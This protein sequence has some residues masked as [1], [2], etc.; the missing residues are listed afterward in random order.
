MM[1][2][3]EDPLCFQEKIFAVPA[4]QAPFLQV[5]H[6]AAPDLLR[7][8]QFLAAA[9]RAAGTASLG[10]F[11]AQRMHRAPRQRRRHDRNGRCF[12]GCFRPVLVVNLGIL[13]GLVV[14]C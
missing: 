7:Q 8:P 10:G 1:M 2:N 4:A 12:G 9:G 13:W 14:M 11:D 3:A 5:L 6:G